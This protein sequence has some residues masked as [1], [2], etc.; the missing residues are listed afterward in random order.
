MAT[1]LFVCLRN[2]GRSQMSAA[3]F[4]R[5]AA[6]RHNV[7]SA[8][9]M[10]VE[11]VHTEVVEVIREL[12]IDVSGSVPRKLTRQLAEGADVVVTMGVATTAPISP[13]SATSTGTSRIRRAGHCTR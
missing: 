2:A 12:G 4:E 11:R 7:L 5:P 1:A 13:A 3:L 8:G 9:T 6:G 10:P